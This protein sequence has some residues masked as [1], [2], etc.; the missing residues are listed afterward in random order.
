MQ[1]DT[2]LRDSQSSTTELLSLLDRYKNYEDIFLEEKVSKF[3][4]SIIVKYS[5]DIEEDKKILFRLIYR[6]SEKK[7][8]ILYNYLNSVIAKK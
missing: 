5:I 7:L 2:R 4:E 1:V 8:N 6:L 3:L